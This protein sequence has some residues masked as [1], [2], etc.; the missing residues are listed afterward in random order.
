M[1]DAKG[2]KTDRPS[3]KKIAAPKGTRDAY[4]DDV[5]RRR[6]VTQAWRDAS[7]RCGFEEI[8]GPTFEQADLYAVKSGDG[9]LSELFQAFSGKSPE[10][11]E[12]V[13]Q[14]GKAPYALRPEFTPTLARMYAARAKQLPQPCK[15]F[16]AGPYFRAEKPQRGRLREF[17]QWNV[18]VVGLAGGESQ[19]AEAQRAEMD[20][21]VVGAIGSLFEQI[22]FSSQDA[23]F[24][25]NNRNWI[26]DLLKKFNVRDDEHEQA[27]SLLDLRS[28]L[29]QTAR[30]ATV[31]N[32]WRG[33]VEFANYYTRQSKKRKQVLEVESPQEIGMNDGDNRRVL[34]G[35]V[36]LFEALDDYKLVDW[37]EIDFDI[38][39][40]LA[41]YTGTVFEV[42]ADGER[43][44]AG[45]GRY[46]NLIELFGGPP[47]PACGFGMGDVV[48]SNLLDD[49]G[50]FPEG[51]E[52]MEAVSR[53]PASVRP[54]AFVIH[55]GSD[56]ARA[57][58][59]PLVAALRRGV[60]A[61]GFDGKP[62]SADRY[63]AGSNG[64]RPM[65]ARQSY[66]ATGNPGKLWS[67]AKKQHARFVIEIGEGGA[68]TLKSVDR[69][70]TIVGGMDGAWSVDPASE[71][72]VGRALMTVL[73]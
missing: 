28:R 44:V 23:R 34:S 25:I 19:N 17:L 30:E 1:S 14:T 46:D 33:S 47:T 10:E 63:A 40:G 39:R 15:W 50:L 24:H 65:H 68:A 64:V 38:V 20:A 69:N 42:I 55:N 21:E 31:A 73:A 51:P 48:L 32:E 70:E 36:N 3:G 7:I 27:I 12:Q 72:F 8:E 43:A 45:G 53:A 52:L 22:G 18:D 59:R 49:K 61:E 29:S 35:A 56:E 71:N 16:T 2:K 11:L 67:D 4:P 9:I 41:Y 62:W 37:S 54:E 60:E 26:R 57:Q 13:Q 6:Y 5:L 66:K 58:V